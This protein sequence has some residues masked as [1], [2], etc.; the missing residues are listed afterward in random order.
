MAYRVAQRR[1]EIGLRVALGA[2]RGTLARDIV[3][4]G[5]RLTVIGIALGLAGSLLLGRFVESM[6]FG[7]QPRDPVAFIAA[8]LVLLVAG[9]AALL[10]PARRAMR[11]DPMT[12]M[13]TE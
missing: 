3:G 10:V 5:L 1:R 7:V 6:L 4:R 11:V 9:V 13:R 2:S 8:P 12:A